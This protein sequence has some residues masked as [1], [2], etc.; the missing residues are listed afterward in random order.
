MKLRYLIP[1][2]PLAETIDFLKKEEK[3]KNN[4]LKILGDDG[5]KFGV[6]PGT[7]DWVH[8]KG[9]LDEFLTLL[10]SESGIETVFLHK[11]AEEPPAGRI[12]LPTSSYEEMGEWVLPS[13]RGREYETLKK[14]V[15]RKYYHLIHGGYFKNFLKKYPEANI[16]HKRMLHVSRNI[17]DT[18]Q[19][20]LSLWRGQCSCAYWHGI[21]GGLYLPH[22]REAIYKNLIEAEQPDQTPQLR[23]IDFDADGEPEIVFSNKNFFTVMKPKTAHFIELDDRT[24]KLNLLN[25]LSRREEKYHQGMAGQ[26]HDTEVKSIHET[27]T[28]K[29]QGLDKYLIYDRY[30][31][32]FGI[33]RILQN[34]PTEDE[35]RCGINIGTIV[36]YERYNILDTKNHKIEFTGPVKKS[37]GLTGADNRT[38]RLQYSG[39]VPL[40][41]VEFS[42]GIFQG[43]LRLNGN[44]L[45]TE[46]ALQKLTEYTLTA[47][48]FTPIT[49][50]AD[51]VF[52]IRAYPIE[53][54]SSS[55]AGFERIFQGIAI[56]HVFTQMPILDIQL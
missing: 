28:S 11:I 54:V 16:M 22:L 30:E 45:N 38:I 37:I 1:F 5:E 42:L 53:T 29:E 9:W 33:D 35:F 8:T 55:E 52:D 50:K 6:W 44:D 48:D 24:R 10:E 13:N 51:Q 4:V 46:L 7:Y 12:Y 40:F 39:T 31:R 2:H 17:V 49:V 20:K 21:F 41:G 14:K 27:A 25:F 56:L 36:E 47:K 18:E 43:D 23:T 32:G 3:K 19:A 15:D 34:V 26:D